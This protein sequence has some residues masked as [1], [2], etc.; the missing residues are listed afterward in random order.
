LIGSRV[1]TRRLASYGSNCIQLAQPPTAC[2]CSVGSFAPYVLPRD[3]SFCGKNVD[4]RSAHVR[5]AFWNSST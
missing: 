1:E 2:G 4:S 5:C 3:V